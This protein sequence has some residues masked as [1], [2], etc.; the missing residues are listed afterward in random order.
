MTRT[1][2]LTEKKARAIIAA[3]RRVGMLNY[4]CQATGQNYHTVRY[5]L[6]QGAAGVE[7]YVDFWVEMNKARASNMRSLVEMAKKDKG[8]P[9]FLLERVFPSDFGPR[10]RSRQEAVQA[11]LDEV[12]PRLDSETRLKVLGVLQAIERERARD[13]E[14]GVADGQSATGGSAPID[15]DGESVEPQL[16]APTEPD[17]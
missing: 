15:V 16:P 9:A 11:L 10:S 1:T 14:L 17:R 2:S 7:P 8:G 6:E 4:A 13:G 5:W 12:L 3:F